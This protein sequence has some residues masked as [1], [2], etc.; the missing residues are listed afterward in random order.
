VSYRTTRHHPTKGERTLDAQY[1]PLGGDE[2]EAPHADAIDVGDTAVD[3]SDDQGGVVAVLRDVTDRENRSRQ[4]RAVDRV[5]QHN[6]RNDLT[7]IRGHADTIR[8]EGSAEMA[9]S[10]DVIRE[11]ADDLLTTSEKSRAVTEI[12]SDPPRQRPIDVADVVD[13]VVRSAVGSHPGARI[14]RRVPPTATAFATSDIDRA[15][16][17]LVRNAIE[18]SDRATPDVTLAVDARGDRVLVR[19]S[20]DG[21]GISKMDRDVVETGA[22]RE[23][24]Y[25]GSGL[26]LWV[27]YWIARRS[28]GSVTAEDA[29]PR[30]T[31]ATMSLPAY[32]E[33]DRRAER[34]VR[35][36]RRLANGRRAGRRRAGR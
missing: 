27:V 19:V 10:A 15:I 28:G 3:R 6:I 12:P 7:L 11:H 17:E 8:S 16:E 36:G 32:Y 14:E 13:T 2:P 26:R 18:H 21:P 29:E 31:R 24:L 20:D 34:A 23:A 1:Y 22:T 35:A 33:P 9:R 25:H 30:G 4:L 5:L